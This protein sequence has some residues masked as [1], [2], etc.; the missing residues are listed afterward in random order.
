[1]HLHSTNNESKLTPRR[2]IA[3]DVTQSIQK[4]LFHLLTRTKINASE[5]HM[6]KTRTI[7]LNSF[8]KNR[9][10]ITSA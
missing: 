5:K 7:K 2:I 3:F 9:F 1:M 10:R 6:K 4:V 8:L